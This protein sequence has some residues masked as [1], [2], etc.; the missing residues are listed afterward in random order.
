LAYRADKMFAFNVQDNNAK[1]FVL[2]ATNIEVVA[3]NGLNG[4]G[5]A[6][7]LAVSNIAMAVDLEDEE[8][9]YKLWYSEDNNDVRFRVAFKIGINVA[10]TAEC[11]KFK[12][13][14]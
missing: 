5:D 12:S 4:T 1:S 11:V 8:M 10:Y 13:T 2:P 6:Y 9:N 7:A 14:I 3:V